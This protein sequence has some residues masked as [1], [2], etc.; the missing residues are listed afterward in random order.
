MTSTICYRWGNWCQVLALFGKYIVFLLRFNLLHDEIAMYLKFSLLQQIGLIFA[1]NIRL[2][3]MEVSLRAKWL[4]A[5][6]R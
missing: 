1:S 3:A 2:G 4:I 5:V 6:S